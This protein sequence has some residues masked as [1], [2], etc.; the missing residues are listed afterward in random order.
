[1]RPRGSAL[2]CR[3]GRQLVVVTALALCAGAAAG[4]VVIGALFAVAVGLV[5]P[6]QAARALALAQ[7]V[8]VVPV[9][10]LAALG[11]YA[12]FQVRRDQ[13]RRQRDDG[14]NA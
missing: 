14:S 11:A 5:G 6:A 10:V 8:G 3:S 12:G 13:K 9:V 7:L 1:V 4:A 2:G